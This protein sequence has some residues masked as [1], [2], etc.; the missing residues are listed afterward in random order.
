MYSSV[1]VM[2]DCFFWNLFLWFTFIVRF[3]FNA[4]QMYRK[5]FS[6]DRKIDFND[7]DL[8]SFVLLPISLWLL[9]LISKY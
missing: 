9:Y 4:G 1:K 2:L 8:S 7:E 3:T 6:F 5:N